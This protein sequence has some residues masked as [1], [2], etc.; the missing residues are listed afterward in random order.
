MKAVNATLRR[1]IVAAAVVL[2][3]PV[4]SSCGTNFNAPTDQVYNPGVGV[5][6]RSGTVDVLHALIVSGATGSGT[7]VAGLVNQDQQHDDQLVSIA[8][9]GEDQ[10][11][12]VNARGVAKIPGGELYQLADQ[13]R[14]T[15]EGESIEPGRFVEL[16]FT[17]ERGE[18][19]TVE[20]PV[21]ARTGAFEDVPVPS[22]A[23]V[24][25]TP[26]EAPTGH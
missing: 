13:G 17:F 7:I 9:S 12:T 24:T 21:V 2:A 1:S 20:V 3:V 8:G 4:L 22:V 25:E 5:N 18:N 15:V 16:T 23:R 19:V 14:Y 11:V 10:T 26:T 6:D